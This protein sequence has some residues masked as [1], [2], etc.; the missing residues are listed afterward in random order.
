MELNV[1]ALTNP[2]GFWGGN[3]FDFNGQLKLQFV[4]IGI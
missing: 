4:Y 2:M 1:L 3:K